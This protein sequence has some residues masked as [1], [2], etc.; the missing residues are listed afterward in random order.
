MELIYFMELDVFL[1]KCV[2][3]IMVVLTVK[4]IECVCNSLDVVKNN[5]DCVCN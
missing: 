2:L 4:I 5:V 1:V 3:E